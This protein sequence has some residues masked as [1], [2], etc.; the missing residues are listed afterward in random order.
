VLF[1]GDR[2]S[3]QLQPPYSQAD[4][5]GLENKADVLVLECTYGN[6]VHKNREEALQKLDKLV[7]DAIEK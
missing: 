4:D 6:R 5:R 2:G 1:S 7:L 3:S